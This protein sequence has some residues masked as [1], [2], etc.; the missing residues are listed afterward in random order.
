MLKDAQKAIDR[1]IDAIDAD[2]K[3]LVFGDYD[4]DGITSSAMMMIC[5]LPFGAQVNF[6]L[7]HRVRDGY[8][9]S[10]KVLNVLP[11]WLY[12]YYYG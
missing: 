12:A 11:Q 7:P 3:I 9:L 4:V 5:L 6:F 1:I 10:V 2:E 8:G